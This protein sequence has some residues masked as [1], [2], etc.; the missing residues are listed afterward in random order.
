MPAPA[1]PSP[2]S[3]KIWFDGDLIA[4]NEARVHVLSHVLHYGSSVFEGIRCYRTESGPAVFRL[5]EHIKRLMFSAKVVRIE[6]PFGPEAVERACLDTIAANGLEECYIRPLVFRGA[7]AMGVLPRDCPVHVAIA[8]WPWGAY[9]GPEALTQ[10]IDAMISTY[11]KLSPNSI[12]ALAK[13]GGA[14]VLA[15]MAKQESVRLGYAEAILLDSAGRVAEGT[16]ENLFAV[17]E[18]RLYTPP[19]ANSILGG[20]TRRSV[21]KLALDRNIPVVEQVLSREMLYM[22]DELFMTG[23]AAEVTPIR[24]VDDL[25]VGNGKPGPITRVLQEDFFA[26]VKGQVA[27]RHGWLTPV[28]RAEVPAD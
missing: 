3:E 14:Y 21:L 17:M 26:V 4:W 2:R 20:I 22:S 18:G 1:N 6:M 23:T 12:P 7:G 9:L 11:S 25:Q 10:G 13:V 5:H 27:D 19:L 16:G 28:V 15:S 24:S 8:V